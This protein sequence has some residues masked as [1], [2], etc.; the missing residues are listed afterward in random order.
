MNWL[1]VSKILPVSHFFLK[2]FNWAKRKYTGM[3][4]SFWKIQSDLMRDAGLYVRVASLPWNS[5]DIQPQHT[6]PPL[7]SKAKIG[8]ARCVADKN[9]FMDYFRLTTPV[10]WA[11]FVQPFSKNFLWYKLNLFNAGTLRSAWKPRLF[12]CGWFKNLEIWGKISQEFLERPAS[13][14]STRQKPQWAFSGCQ[15]LA[16]YYWLA[17][18][19]KHKRQFYLENINE[20]ICLCSSKV[21]TNTD[22]VKPTCPTFK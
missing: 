15:I 10:P 2:P 8:Q 3:K 6:L 19:I 12:T 18:Q 1:V 13:Y 4:I 14:Y 20:R 22:T 17:H 7:N 9:S 11:E 21:K 16:L 5:D